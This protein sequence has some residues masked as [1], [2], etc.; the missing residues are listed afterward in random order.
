MD[1][2]ILNVEKKKLLIIGGGEKTHVNEI[3]RVP[4]VQILQYRVLLKIAQ[5]Y[6]VFDTDH[7]GGMHDLNYPIRRDD[8]LL[9]SESI[10]HSQ[11]QQI[12]N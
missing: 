6:H 2:S 8:F 7:R 10:M 5:L 4:Q 3:F 1:E 9:K 11:R 12:A